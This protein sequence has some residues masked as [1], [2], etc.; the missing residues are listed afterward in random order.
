MATTMVMY[1]GKRLIPAPLVSVTKTYQRTPDQTVVG[2]IF[3]LTIMGTL[4]AYMGSPS[5]TG[6]FWEMPDYPSDESIAH[7]SRLK[8]ILRKQ[9]AMREL[10]SNDGYV[11]E[12][13]SADGTQPMKCNPRVIDI[14]FAE[15][16]WFDSIQ[17]TI[18]LE[19]DTL[20]VNGQAI[21]ED[22]FDDFISDASESWAFE[23]D[24]TPE[25]INLPRTYRLTH[26]VSA[27]GKRYF[28]ETGTLEKPAWQQAQSYVLGRLG[29]VPLVAISSGVYYGGYNH[30]RSTN[31]DELAGSFSVNESWLLAS[32]IALE[33]FNCEIKNEANNGTTSVSIQGS[34]TGLEE[35]DSNLNLVTPK[36]TNAE[37]QWAVV[38]SS[39][40]SRAQNYSGLTLNPVPLSKMIG[41]NDINGNI[42][43][44]YDYDNRA[45][46]LFADMSYE[47][48]TITENR[49]ADLFAS[50]AV[51]GRAAG[52]V[53]QNLGS[54]Q[55]RSVTLN[56]ELVQAP[57]SFASGTTA[58]IRSA[59][60]NN[61]R[62]TQGAVFDTVLAAA[63]P[64]NY[65]G[66]TNQFVR[67]Q[68]E[69]WDVKSGRYSYNIEWVFGN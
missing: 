31:Q 44:A 50:I 66:T 11:F 48:I 33:E 61:P 35:R 49:P 10:F 12:I 52:P 22:D 18:T 36:Y 8:S 17:Y 51:I 5:S 29:Y 28:D 25:G 60:Y 24:E 63:Q 14:S 37:T 46:N 39:L 9:E 45:S 6:V 64:L 67:S 55:E 32:G 56:I 16:Q 21:D 1:N 4:V 38:Q 43:Y 13:Q 47:G 23:T 54:A 68:S 26:I 19:S 20:S 34:I 27:T 7:N 15:G 59:L 58:Q 3:R 69:N 42:T 53:L 41:K 65:Y 57:T 2:A 30:I 62:V 40:L